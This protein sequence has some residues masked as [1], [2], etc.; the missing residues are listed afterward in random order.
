MRDTRLD[1]RN[2]DPSAHLPDPLATVLRDPVDEASIPRLWRRIEERRAA[3]GVPLRAMLGWA[4]V[5][6]AIAVVVMLLFGVAPEAR[7]TRVSSAAGAASAGPLVLRSGQPIQPIAV[8]GGAP[9]VAV[10]LSDGSRLTLD[11]G[12]RLE[13]LVATDREVLF[14]LAQGRTLFDVRPGGPRRWIIEAGI[15]SVEVVGTEFSVDRQTD[16]VRVEVSRGVVLVRAQT[17]PDG[18]ARLE[19]RGVLEVRTRETR[20]A[21]VAL[22]APAASTAQAATPRAEP[23][24]PKASPW[25]EAA[26]LGEYAQAYGSLG[27]DGLSRETARAASADDLF[28]LADVARLSGHP[29]EAVA[30]LERLVTD[31]GASPRAALARVTLGRIELDLGEPLKASAALER[32]LARGVPAG[33]QEDVYVRLVEAHVKA[34][35]RGAARAAA[36]A[37]ARDVPGGRRAPDIA[38]W[39]SR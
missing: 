18:V 31:Y 24:P 36:A 1:P 10:D 32:A 11:A 13:P 20:P 29:A 27:A 6:A 9:Q 7:V 4:S 3:P 12:T 22:L 37:Y 16:R 39:L 5:G 14:R 23:S 2:E 25:R 38:R 28:S 30:P 21:E 26:A 34:G 8:A 19:A 33:L 35:N 15:A 17:L